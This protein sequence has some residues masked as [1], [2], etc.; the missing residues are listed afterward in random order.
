MSPLVLISNPYMLGLA[1]NIVSDLVNVIKTCSQRTLG[2]TVTNTGKWNDHQVWIVAQ[3]SNLRL[4]KGHE[5]TWDSQTLS[6]HLHQPPLQGTSLD[7]R[8]WNERHSEIKVGFIVFEKPVPK[9]PQVMPIAFPQCSSHEV[10]R[11]KCCSSAHS[12]SWCHTLL[13]W[14]HKHLHKTPCN[15]TL[16]CFRWITTLIIFGLSYSASQNDITDFSNISG[17]GQR[18]NKS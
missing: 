4:T 18:R 17:K 10:F 5:Q 6:P 3:Y 14:K 13:D 2:N 11:S 9:K 7:L 12:W 15:Y 16:V 8:V 1:L